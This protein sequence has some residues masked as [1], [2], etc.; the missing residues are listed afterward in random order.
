MTILGQSPVSTWSEAEAGFII[1]QKNQ[2]DGGGGGGRDSG[3]SSASP[4]E[5][6]PSNERRTWNNLE[7]SSSSGGG[8]LSSSSQDLTVDETS[9][10]YQQLTQ[11]LAHNRINFIQP[12]AELITSESSAALTPNHLK[13]VYEGRD[14]LA[15]ELDAEK[16][17]GPSA[18]SRPPTP[19]GDIAPEF[20]DQ[21]KTNG[22]LFPQVLAS[23]ALA[24]AAMIEGYSSGYTSPALASMTSPNSTIPVNDQEASWIGSLMPL[25]A[26][27]GG[28]VGGTII[29]RYGRKKTIMATG[30]P[31]ILSWLLITF[32]TNLSMVYAGRSIQGFCVGLTTLALPIYLG[33]TIQ[34][35]VRGTLGLLPTTIGNIGILFCYILGSYID[36]KILAAIGAFLPLPFLV[37]M[38]FIPE[39]PRWYIAQ[40]RYHEAR[41]SLQW[42]RG[43][44]TDIDDEFMEIETN[45]KSTAVQSSS[46]KELMKM[47]YVRPLLIS[48]G[49]MFFQ[50]LSGINAV[51]F[52]T[53]SIFEKSGG[54]VDSNLS[55]IIIGLANFFATLGSN[56]VIDRIGRKVLLNVSGFFMALSLGV[57]GTFFLMQHL[58]HDVTL[59]GWLP[60]ASFIVYII[61]FS[62]GYGPIP[63]LMMGEIFPGKVRGHA[64]SVAT[65]FNWACSFAVTKSFN[66]LTN[67]IGAHGAFWFFGICCFLS[68][69]F[70]IFFVP[71][72]KGHSLENIEK[73][74]LDKKSKGIQSARL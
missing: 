62:I 71:E 73:H 57:L 27:L 15:L 74:M 40:G 41:D 9:R 72:T 24:I 8:S 33:E 29:E 61:A 66:D 60:L 32:A 35:H 13:C 26:L 68:I 23:L 42:F 5:V 39:T 16:R 20:K 1:R 31:Y 3:R 51:I 10:V 17:K 36:W 46:I 43:S 63:W 64:A 19:S 52:Y 53:V 59:F 67:A 47:A 44:K 2:T 70:V 55:S 45:Y 37:F 22:R 6:S 65:A 54:S 21:T 25:N 69:F 50:Q 4:P 48:L 12:E 14:N 7:E 38:W 28:I 34:P 18:P 11:T 30:P 58:E 49:L 56:L